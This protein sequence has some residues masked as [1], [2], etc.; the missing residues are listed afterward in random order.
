MT[1]KE[2]WEEWKDYFYMNV[3]KDEAKKIWDAARKSMEVEE[4]RNK[5]RG[6]YSPTKKIAKGSKYGN[7]Q[8]DGHNYL[9]PDCGGYG[10]LLD[11]DSKCSFCNGNGTIALDDDR[12]SDVPTEGNK[13]EKKNAKT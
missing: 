4:R 13:K 10:F 7:L 6:C 11:T 5:M 8:S 12:V 3:E 1:F 9:C 2:Y